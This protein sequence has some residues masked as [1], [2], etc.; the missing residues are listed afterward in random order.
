L[1]K[2]ILKEKNMTEEQKLYI[3]IGQKLK[4]VEESQLFGKPC[5]KIKGKAFIC[6]FKTKWFSC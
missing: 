6:F 5:F 3:E 1:E 2:K 4:D